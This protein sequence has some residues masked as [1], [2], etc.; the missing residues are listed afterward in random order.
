M[1]SGRP[2]LHPRIGQE[3]G[4]TELFRLSPGSRLLL[5]HLQIYYKH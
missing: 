4:G 1:L 5:K 3:Y 2:V